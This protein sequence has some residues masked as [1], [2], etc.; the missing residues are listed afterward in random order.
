M[1][2]DNVLT[3]AVCI[4]RGSSLPSASN[5]L[6]NGIAPEFENSENQ[7]DST[8]GVDQHELTEHHLQAALSSSQIETSKST[9]EGGKPAYHIPTPKATLVL[10]AEQ[11]EQEY[12]HNA[13]SDPVTYVRFS[14]VLEDLGRGVP[15]CLDDEDQLWLDKH[16][17][18]V[19]V[20]IAQFLKDPKQANGTASGKDKEKARS[21]VLAS[22]AQEKPDKFLTIDEDQFETVMYVFETTTCDRHPLLELDASKIPTLKELLPAFNEDSPLSQHAIRELP[23]IAE[24][25]L[26]SRSPGTNG[27]GEASKET[28]AAWSSANPFKNLHLLKVCAKVVYQWWKLRREEREG[29]P[30]VPSL[31]FDESNENDP[32]VCFR[33]REVKS[34]RKTRKTGNLQL[35]KLVRLRSELHQ[36][37]KLLLL[38]AQRE[39]VKEMQVKQSREGWA[40]A[41]ELM[42]IR[43]TWSI[44]AAT[45]GQS[46]EELM[47]SFQ[48]D[49]LAAMQAAGAASATAS[50]QLKKKRRA[51]EMANASNPAKLRRHKGADADAAAVAKLDSDSASGGIGGSILD[52]VQTVQAYVE[53][54]KQYKQQADAGFEDL[55]DWT[56]QP[57]VAPPS[58]R[59]FRPIQTDNNDT[60]FWSNH[61]Y[62]RMGR[63][64]CFRRRTGRGGRVYLDRRPMT[65]SP[66]PAS[67]M[68][69]PKSRSDG[70]HATLRSNL[71]ADW[72]IRHD[73]APTLSHPKLS[74]DAYRWAMANMYPKLSGP[75]AFASWVKPTQLP[76]PDLN[77]DPMNDEAYYS[78]LAKKA[79]SKDDDGK[80]G[81]SSLP[82]VEVSSTASDSTD[83]SRNSDGFT[84]GAST[85]AT[86]VAE[87]TTPEDYAKLD[88]DDE[89]DEAMSAED[90]AERYQR[91][92]ERWRFDEDGGRWAGLGLFG[93]GGMEGDEEAVLDDFDQRFVRY[94]MSLL[95][96]ASLLKLSTDWTYMRRA[97]A[98]SSVSAPSPS[99]YLPQQ[100]KGQQTSSGDD[101]AEQHTPKENTHKQGSAATA[102]DSDARSKGAQPNGTQKEKVATATE[103]MQVV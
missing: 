82:N 48:T 40:Q 45:K 65:P 44:P 72:A 50:A 34:T 90:H 26:P 103:E 97:L 32:Y 28:E 99:A 96:E 22:L 30:I 23:P 35:E 52:R 47:F 24:D 70:T 5:A 81:G 57:T 37:S 33:R 89:G 58:L 101:A 83:R 91:L 64:S 66:A 88:I 19:R 92:A 11:Y 4:Q 18:R 59:A 3:P 95:D 46:D 69:W 67:L 17:D 73:S 39:R 2:C 76:T 49:P 15:Y 56:F 78:V 51:E 36:A 25:I 100:E 13:Y 84:D 94:R 12:P 31:N 8:F 21:N 61:P 42:D 75:F 79:Q 74:S 16:N 98:A 85:Q 55:S 38:V 77:Y 43:K 29:K 20:E 63:Q 14:E 6:V 27:A 102:T 9:V 87:T 71:A 10:S 86:D 68:A 60:Q 53:R 62:A 1:L 41:C 54:E 80:E 7:Q 93:L